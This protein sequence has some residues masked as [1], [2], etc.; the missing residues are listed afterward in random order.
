MTIAVA[1]TV[2]VTNPLAVVLLDLKSPQ[3]QAEVRAQALREVEASRRR[4][5]R[6]AERAAKSR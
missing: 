1:G 2:P 4:R 6:A 3:V 5:L